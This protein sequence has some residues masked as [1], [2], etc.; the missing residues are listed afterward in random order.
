MFRAFGTLREMLARCAQNGPENLTKY[1][2]ICFA[3][4]WSSLRRLGGAGETASNQ[5]R[6]SRRQPIAPCLDSC[7]WRL[8][9][10]WSSYPYRRQ[11]DLPT[12]SRVERGRTSRLG[13]RT[14]GLRFGIC[15]RNTIKRLRLSFVLYSSADSWSDESTTAI[16]P[17]LRFP[18]RNFMVPRR[19]CSDHYLFRFRRRY[20]HPGT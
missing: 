18:A 10:N 20:S 19:F 3:C 8:L 12:L 1:P 11:F 2:T 17:G 4:Q 9:P 6:T 16:C 13:E 7:D 15:N 14:A 5:G